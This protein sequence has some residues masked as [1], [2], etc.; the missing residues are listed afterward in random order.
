MHV[1]MMMSSVCMSIPPPP[2]RLLAI[3]KKVVRGKL[4]VGCAGENGTL[5]LSQRLPA[6]EPKVERG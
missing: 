5:F 2:Q 6:G 3:S 4:H 1:I